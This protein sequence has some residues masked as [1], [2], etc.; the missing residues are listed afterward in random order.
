MSDETLASISLFCASLEQEVKFAKLNRAAVSKVTKFREKTVFFTEYARLVIYAVLGKSVADTIW[1]G[2]QLPKKGGAHA[3]FE[4]YWIATVLNPELSWA[5][6]TGTVGRAPQ[7]E[8]IPQTKVAQAKKPLRPLKERLPGIEK[9]LK[10]NVMGQDEAIETTLDILYRAAAGLSDPDRPQAVLLFTGPSGSGKTHLAKALCVAIFEDDPTPDKIAS[11]PAFMRIDCTL[12]QQKHE[13]SN[14]IGSPQG[15][16]GSDLGS[17]LP[18][19]LKEHLPGNVVLVDEVEKAHQS[20]HKIF[21]G[22]FDYGKIKDNKQAEVE[23]RNSIF[24]M[25]SNAGSSEAHDELN[26]LKK[27]LGF[28]SVSSDLQKLTSKAYQKKIEEIFPP[29][30]RGRIDEIVIF[31]H[32]DEPSYKKILDLELEKISRR[33]SAK[34]ITLR[35]TAGAKQTILSES[36]S[37]EL[38]AR[39][40]SQHVRERVTKPLSRL[41]VSSNSNKYI[42]RTREGTLYVEEV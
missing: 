31:Q 5:L 41:I 40:L 26:K 17:P 22:L 16:I 2:A 34:G 33:L 25:T 10:E 20:L 23:A 18:D 36:V 3:L 8:E 7:I 30:F 35:V 28:V 24:I 13:I 1:S 37:P 14:L 12:Y 27:P 9:F 29:E 39:R 38:G 4:L 11:P 19:F 42:C 6:K 32:L 15:Y 21:M